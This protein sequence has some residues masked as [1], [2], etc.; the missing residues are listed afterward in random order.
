MVRPVRLEESGE[1]SAGRLSPHNDKDR[2]EVYALLVHAACCVRT[3]CTCSKSHWLGC[4][5]ASFL[6]M[7]FGG[8][9]KVSFES[10]PWHI[11]NAA[12]CADHT[13]IHEK[14]MG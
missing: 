7:Q 13:T 1:T 5:A 12:N 8:R 4:L 3:A 11:D 10:R 14:Q 2:G 6:P 9:F